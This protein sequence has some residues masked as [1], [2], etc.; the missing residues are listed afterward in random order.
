MHQLAK[1]NH[2]KLPLGSNIVQNECYMDDMLSGGSS[3]K[4][5]LEKQSQLITLL[6]VGGKNLR[7]WIENHPT[8]LDHLSSDQLATEPELLFQNSTTF[9]VLGLH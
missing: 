6:K 7:K 9:T 3:I 4:E 5:A 1:D 8:L 2:Q